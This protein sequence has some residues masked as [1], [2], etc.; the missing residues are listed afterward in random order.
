M[1]KQK[2]KSDFKTRSFSHR[3]KNRTERNLIR[4]V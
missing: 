4:E 3:F 1:V 2:V